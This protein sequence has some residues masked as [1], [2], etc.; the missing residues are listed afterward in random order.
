MINLVWK[1]DSYYVAIVYT[2]Q[3]R[4]NMEDEPRVHTHVEHAG[5]DDQTMMS[6]AVPAKSLQLHTQNKKREVF[7]SKHKTR[8]VRNDGSK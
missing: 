7:N 8:S 3:F 2:C 5:L 6:D 1:I 4:K